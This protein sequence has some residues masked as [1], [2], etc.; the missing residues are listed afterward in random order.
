MSGKQNTGKKYTYT[1]NEENSIDL[2]EGVSYS[3]ISKKWVVRIK[4]KLKAPP[5]RRLNS[6]A[7][8]DKKEDA[9]EHYKRLSRE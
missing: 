6:I 7:Q 9:E 5:R 3:T 1:S 4:N 2:K 8:Y